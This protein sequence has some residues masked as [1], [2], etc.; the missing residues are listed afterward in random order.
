MDGWSPWHPR[1]LDYSCSKLVEMDDLL[2]LLR[3]YLEYM[4]PSE[5]LA[6]DADLQ[7]VGLDSM[8]AI[9]LLLEVEE[10]FNIV[11]PDDR[12][13]DETFATP[14]ALWGVISELSG[15]ERS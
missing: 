6:E 4:E 7:S 1:L 12:L 9:D 3:P 8:G 10:H 13:V 15:R 2:A 14:K 5:R 11:I